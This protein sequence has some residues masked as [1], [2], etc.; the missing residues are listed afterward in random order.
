IEGYRVAGKTG[1][2]Q[3]VDP[4]TKRYSKRKYMAAFVGFTPV[5]SPKLLVAVAIDEPKGSYYGGVVA[6]P[7]FKEVGSWSLAHLRISPETHLASSKKKRE[8]V[9]NSETLAKIQMIASE[10]RKQNITAGAM[11]DFSGM[12]LREVLTRTRQLGVVAEVEGSGF[13]VSQE[14]SPGTPLEK[15]ATVKVQFKSPA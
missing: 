13:A 4:E 3:K 10:L 6:A 15:G 5:A 2:S 9:W 1:T 14:P 7:V 11:P 8:P 12:G